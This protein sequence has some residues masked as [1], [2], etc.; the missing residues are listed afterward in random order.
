MPLSAVT[1]DG[2][3]VL[4]SRLTEMDRQSKYYYCRACGQEMRLRIPHARV[5][6]FFHKKNDGCAYGGESQYHLDAK[7]RIYD[8]L[9]QRYE[10]VEM[11]KIIEIYG[12]TR[13]GDVVVPLSPS[14]IGK[15]GTVVEIQN[16]SI[17][18]E[19]IGSRIHDWN[20][21]GYAVLWVITDKAMKLKGKFSSDAFSIRFSEHRIP[22]WILNLY[23]I[24]NTIYLYSNNCMF[25]LEL[26]DVWHSSEYWDEVT[27]EVTENEYK[28]KMTKTIKAH[29]LVKLLL[30]PRFTV[31]Y[32]RFAERLE[33]R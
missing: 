19:E 33:C 18:A 23:N 30:T 2:K 28:L 20:M 4:A 5:T 24:Y 32:P 17:S 7:Q 27:G 22:R 9:S 10:G 13:I 1:V 29:R 12:K 31:T 25:R 6:H 8:E 16:S 15:F 26:E 21:Q 14:N 11:E 3:H